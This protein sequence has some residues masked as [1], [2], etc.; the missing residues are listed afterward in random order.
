M[1]ATTTSVEILQRIGEV[2]PMCPD[3]R[4]G[5]LMMTLDILADDMFD[6]NLWDVEDDQLIAVIERFRQDLVR[7]ES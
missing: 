1:T 4:F 3:M 7:R 5:Q 2:H 6:R